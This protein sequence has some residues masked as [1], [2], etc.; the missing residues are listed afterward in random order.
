MILII[1]YN[2]LGVIN[3]NNYTNK[4]NIYIYIYIYKGLLFEIMPLY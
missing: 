3:S 2:C 4:D 1:N